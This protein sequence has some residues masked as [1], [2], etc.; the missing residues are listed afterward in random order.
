MEEELKKEQ[1][2]FGLL[3]VV[4]EDVANRILDE[5]TDF[6]R[7]SEPAKRGMVDKVIDWLGESN[8][9]LAGAILGNTEGLLEAMRDSL[10]DKL[11]WAEHEDLLFLMR[12]A[13]LLVLRVLNEALREKR[14]DY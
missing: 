10:A 4:S 12:Y 13:H 8:S 7:L 9:E 6:G 3:P 11:T 2:E 1:W 14:E 5:M